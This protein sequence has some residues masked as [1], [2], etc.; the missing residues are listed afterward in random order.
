MNPAPPD[1]KVNLFIYRKLNYYFL[2]RLV[3]KQGQFSI[4]TYFGGAG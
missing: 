3:S 4:P 1:I 2:V